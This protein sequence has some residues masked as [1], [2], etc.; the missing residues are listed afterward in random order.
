M[1]GANNA[2]I[3]SKQ[4]QNDSINNDYNSEENQLLRELDK[5]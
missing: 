2:W 4:K 5:M 1:G 3:E